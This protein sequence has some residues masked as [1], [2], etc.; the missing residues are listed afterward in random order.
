MM[1][2]GCYI[3]LHVA[4]LQNNFHE[5][6]ARWGVLH[7]SV[8]CVVGPVWENFVSTLHATR[9]HN[10]HARSTHWADFYLFTTAG[11]QTRGA[12]LC[13][14]VWPENKK[15][16]QQRFKNTFINRSLPASTG[17]RN[18]ATNHQTE[19][20]KQS[21]NLEITLLNWVES[22]CDVWFATRDS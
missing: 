7:F 8:Y 20:E 10:I 11:R 19:T 18:H 3:C 4:Q 1:N 15:A 12:M 2:S 22:K 9:S 16:N 17:C 13:V 6:V 14:E 5:R 21:E